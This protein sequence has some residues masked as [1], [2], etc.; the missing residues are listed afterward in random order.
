MPAV[1]CMN[2]QVAQNAIHAAGVFFSRSKDGTGRGRFQI[3]DRDWIVIAQSPGPGA[4]IGEGDAVLTVVKYT[5][6]NPC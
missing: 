3:L 5:E 6:P 1:V 4:L 2:L